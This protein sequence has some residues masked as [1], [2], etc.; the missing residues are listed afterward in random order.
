MAGHFQ[1]AQAIVCFCGFPV[2]EQS[3]K[4]ADNSNADKDDDIDQNP[5]K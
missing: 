3:S 1:V 5:H 2:F 4:E